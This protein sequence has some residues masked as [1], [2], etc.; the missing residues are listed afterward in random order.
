MLTSVSVGCYDER[1]GQDGILSRSHSAS[2]FHT[3]YL[4]CDRRTTRSAA[5][6][7]PTTLVTT[8]AWTGGADGDTVRGGGGSDT[9]LDD[10]SEIDESFTYWAEWVDVV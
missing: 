8:T 2:Y 7:R 4:E 10:E 3:W 1:R 9:M 5:K 6:Q